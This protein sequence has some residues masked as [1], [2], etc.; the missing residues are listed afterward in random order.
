MKWFYFTFMRSTSVHTD[1]Y[2]KPHVHLH[3]TLPLQNA[4]LFLHSH[5]LLTFVPGRCEES[6]TSVIYKRNDLTYNPFPKIL[7][8][9]F[10]QTFVLQYF[11][12]SF[13]KEFNP[14]V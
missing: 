9:E 14:S 5:S 11:Q 1:I 12:H 10:K 2:T 4:H 13:I 3:I 8:T 7:L 6:D